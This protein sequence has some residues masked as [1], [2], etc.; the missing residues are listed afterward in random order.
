MKRCLRN[1]KKEMNSTQVTDNVN[2]SERSEMLK[3][4]D[5]I[6][7]YVP[8]VLMVVG[9]LCNI[10]VILVMRTSFF[11]HIST[12]LYITVNACID[13]VSLTVAL[14]VHWIYVNFP[15]VIYR[16]SNSDVICKLINFIGWGTS[17]LGI[18]LTA[19]MTFERAFAIKY[20]LKAPRFCTIQKVKYVIVGLV[21]VVTLKD[22]F[23]LVNS[24]MVD[25]EVGSHLCTFDTGDD[26]FRYFVEKVF[27][28]IHNVVLVL[29]F[30]VICI[31]NIIIINSVKRSG[32][33]PPSSPQNGTLL[34]RTGNETG[35][36]IRRSRRPSN[37]KGRQLTVILISDSLTIVV[38]T[39]PFAIY[40]AIQPNVS[41]TNPDTGHL[42]F[43]ITFYLLYV[44]R[45]VNFFLY[46][47][48]GEKFRHALKS[49]VT[50]KEERRLSVF[51]IQIGAAYSQSAIRRLSNSTDSQART[52]YQSSSN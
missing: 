7:L 42:I 18:Y 45:C 19:A 14:P 13:N 40:T 51:A 24:V 49:L 37:F 22:G 52:E 17:D 12:S 16:G 15:E 28:V 43:A 8:P 44:N 33:F 47:S 39:L 3:I 26:S 21:V 1:V 46:C 25:V 29:S 5:G 27:P 48:S 4:A 31:S 36:T 9:L 32:A 34:R 50:K 30:T 2:T 35:D 10:L 23:L 11:V 41:F 20:P 6:D 38:C